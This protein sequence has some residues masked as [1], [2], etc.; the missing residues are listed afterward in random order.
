[1]EYGIL[2]LIVP[3]ANI[4]AIFKIWTSGA[5]ALAKII[6]AVVNFVVPVLGFIIW[7]IAGPKG[8]NSAHV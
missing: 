5:T 3:I 4:Y 1:M 2:G 8:G 6:W 7:L